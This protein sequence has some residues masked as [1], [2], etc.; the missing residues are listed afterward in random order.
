LNGD[1]ARWLALN[2][3]TYLGAPQTHTNDHV[4]I[5]YHEVDAAFATRMGDSITNWVTVACD[6]LTCDGLPL[7]RVEILSRG[8]SQID[9]SSDDPWLLRVPSPYIKRARSDLPFSPE[10]QVEVATLLAER[11]VLQAA[12]GIPAVY[13]ADAYFLQQGVISWLV[14]RFVLIDTESFL[15]TSLAA[16]YGDL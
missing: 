10:L 4:I 3:S 1:G 5:N 13:P 12:N 15:I 6:A 9:W 7:I 2:L 8:V 16:N 14:G 11:I